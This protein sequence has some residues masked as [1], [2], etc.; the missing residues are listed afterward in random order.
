MYNKKIV[1]V[2]PCFKVKNKILDVITKIP[3]WIHKII[4]VDDN[5][6]E[7]SGKFIQD[8]NKKKKTFSNF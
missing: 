8:N 7:G 4:C 5:C 2:I 6:P 3:E 1:I